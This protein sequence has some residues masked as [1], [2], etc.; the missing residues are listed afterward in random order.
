MLSSIY[1][2]IPKYDIKKTKYEISMT[3]LCLGLVSER[4]GLKNRVER[5]M[6]PEKMNEAHH[7]L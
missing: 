6:T 3:N 2:Y 5:E 4:T 1:F 7:Y